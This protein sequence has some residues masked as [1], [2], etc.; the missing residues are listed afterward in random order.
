MP[1]VTV[2]IVFKRRVGYYM[3]QIYIPSVFLV[4]LSWLAFL[5]EPANIA[6][7]LS[8]EVTMIL[9]IVVLL[10][11]VNA[12]IPKVSYLKASDWYVFTSFIFI[13]MAL[14]E[15]MLVY[16]IKSKTTTQEKPVVSLVVD[17]L[18]TNI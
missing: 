12:T 7:R 13:S 14:L 6:D 1:K 3:I 9:S 15:T 4:V 16:R 2:A 11:G 10:G 5:M 18:F 8:L 17:K